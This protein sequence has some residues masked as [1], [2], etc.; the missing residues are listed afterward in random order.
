MGLSARPANR[1]TEAGRS[2]RGASDAENGAACRAGSAARAGVRAP[3]G[4][5]RRV[6][7]SRL[8]PGEDRGRFP[9]QDARRSGGLTC[10]EGRAVGAATIQRSASVVRA[11]VGGPDVVPAALACSGAR[12]GRR[13]L[14]RAARARRVRGDGLS[15]AMRVVIAALVRAHDGGDRHKHQRQADDDRRDAHPD[16]GRRTGEGCQATLTSGTSTI[17]GRRPWPASRPPRAPPRC[18]TPSHA[19]SR[20]SRRP[21]P[22]RSRL[23]NS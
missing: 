9:R 22:S 18:P 6:G 10:G 21:W 2:A 3:V 17:I 13:P 23:S 14:G 8:R 4:T 5:R 1:P 20:T 16:E 15:T 7:A 11:V 12:R 19:A